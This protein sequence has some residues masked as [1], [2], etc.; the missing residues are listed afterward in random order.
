MKKYVAKLFSLFM[1]LCMVG[2]LLVPS[3]MAMGN[4]AVDAVDLQTGEV[5]SVSANTSLLMTDDEAASSPAFVV[6]HGVRVGVKQIKIYPALYFES[7]GIIR[8]FPD[9]YDTLISTTASERSMYFDMS[10]ERTETLLAKYKSKTGID[11]DAWYVEVTYVIYTDGNGSYGKYFEYNAVG[12]CLEG[13]TVRY[14]ITKNTAL[15]SIVTLP[16]SF[17]MPENASARY[18]IGLSGGLYYYSAYA[19]KELGTMTVVNVTL[20]STI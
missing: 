20:N 6:T 11:A 12:N 14:N 10:S 3:A 9:T 13:T 19:N 17:L 2:T 16:A 5:A 8:Y 18:T 15:Q 7:E 1:A 4:S